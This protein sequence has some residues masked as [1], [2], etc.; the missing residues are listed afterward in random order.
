MDN[1]QHVRTRSGR[2]AGAIAPG[3]QGMR[4]R[5]LILRAG[6]D[7]DLALQTFAC[8]RPG[9]V[10]AF[11]AAHFFASARLPQALLRRFPHAAIAGCSTAGEIAHDRVYDDTC[12]ITAVEFDAATVVVHAAAIACMQD[13]RAAGARLAAL[14]APADL[15]AVLLF[16][17]GVGINGSALIAGFQSVLPGVA[18]SGGLAGDGGRF[19]ETWTLGPRGAANDQLVAVGLYGNALRVAHGCFAGWVPF[20]P[21]RKVTRCRDNVLYQLDGERAL[22]VYRSYLGDYAKDLPASGLLFPMEMLDAGRRETG[23]FR[24]IIGVGQDEGSLTLAGDVDP[25]GYLRLMHASTARLTDGAERAGRQVAAAAQPAG[26]GEA[27]AIL[28]SCVG[29]KLVM[30]DRVEE[31]V[32][33]AVAALGKSTAV[34]GFYSNGE[35]AGGTPHGACR[36]HNQTMTITWMQEC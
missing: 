8:G 14:F 23:V 12:V 17:T 35:I 10:L 21:V 3:V 24:T 11:G 25:D 36:L 33:A 22:D 16:G 5:Q 18:L 4:T 27:L 6:G 29:R 28:V 34:A 9:L 32:E 15:A 30:G 7:P 26:A 31:E 1:E 2:R 20:G 13:S 19:A